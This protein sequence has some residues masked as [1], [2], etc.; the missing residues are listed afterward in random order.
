MNFIVKRKNVVCCY[1]P[2]L[3]SLFLFACS[4]S[5]DSQVSEKRDVLLQDYEKAFNPTKYNLEYNDTT[6]SNSNT[7]RPTSSISRRNISGFRIQI[8]ISREF[9]ECQKRRKELQMLFPDQKIY[10][11]HE[12]PFYK[13]RLGNFRTR[14]EAESYLQNLSDNN[15]KSTQ[16][17]PDRIVVE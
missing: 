5:K 9:D 8:V 1:L 16:I 3:L 14:G 13:L 2:I 12:F 15:I 10:I 4:A 7:T 17:V 6:A 11:I